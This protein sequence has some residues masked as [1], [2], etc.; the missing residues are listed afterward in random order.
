RRG[1]LGIA[2]AI[3]TRRGHLVA[4]FVFE[5]AAY[6]VLAALVGAAL[7]TAVAYGMVALIARALGTTGLDV[8]F[9][10]TGRSLAV[11]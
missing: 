7:G 5:G 11:A 3:G 8:Q 10:V 2:R 9:A 6:D 4:L 1:E